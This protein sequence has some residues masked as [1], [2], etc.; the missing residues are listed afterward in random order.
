MDHSVEN[1]Q[2]LLESDLKSAYD[3][4]AYYAFVLW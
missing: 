3:C 4:I 2:R 1:A